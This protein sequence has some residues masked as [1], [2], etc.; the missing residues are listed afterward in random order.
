[1]RAPSYEGYAGRC[2]CGAE[3]PDEFYGSSAKLISAFRD[4]LEADVFPTADSAELREAAEGFALRG[5]LQY[6]RMIESTEVHG[7]RHHGW[8]VSGSEGRA[9]YVGTCGT[10]CSL[11]PWEPL[12]AAQDGQQ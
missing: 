9:V 6:L 1:M 11:G 8:L 10:A 2:S 4:H 3:P 5:P 12:T 7:V